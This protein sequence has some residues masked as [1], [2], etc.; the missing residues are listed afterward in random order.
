MGKR[1]RNVVLES[2]TC[3]SGGIVGGA[4][5]EYCLAGVW[6]GTGSVGASRAGGAQVSGR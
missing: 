1:E 2:V 3:F 4:V 5:V 6:S